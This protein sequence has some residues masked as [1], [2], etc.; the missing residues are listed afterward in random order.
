MGVTIVT[1]LTTIDYT[2]VTIV[3]PFCWNAEEQGAVV[4]FF[5][6]LICS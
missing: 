4:F 1:R 3:T 6:I 2:G 5:D